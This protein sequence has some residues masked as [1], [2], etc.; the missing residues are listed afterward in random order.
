MRR[1]EVADERGLAQVL[2][3][4]DGVLVVDGAHTNDVRAGGDALVADVDPVGALHKLAHLV[5]GLA[6]E[7]A[8]QLVLADAVNVVV[9]GH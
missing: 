9:T 6:A 8:V 7:R 4:D 5:A 2:V 1:R 3:L